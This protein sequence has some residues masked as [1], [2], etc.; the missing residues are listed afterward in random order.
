MAASE[1]TR[2]ILEAGCP[3]V[4]EEQL[5]LAH[6]RLTV[7]AAYVE[8]VKQLVYECVPVQFKVDVIGK[9]APQSTG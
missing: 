6:F 7:D 9:N 4:Q 2:R 5:G 3:D 1:L 8:A